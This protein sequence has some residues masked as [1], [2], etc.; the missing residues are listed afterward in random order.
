MPS[1]KRL[2]ELSTLHNTM[3][4]TIVLRLQQQSWKSMK[5]ALRNVKSAAGIFSLH[6]H[7]GRAFYHCRAIQTFPVLCFISCSDSHTHT[8]SLSSIERKK[9]QTETMTMQQVSR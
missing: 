8:H 9:S 2:G 6:K 1:L 4:D 3:L 7:H 5:S